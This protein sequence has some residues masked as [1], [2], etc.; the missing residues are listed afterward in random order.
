MTR[1]VAHASE[2]VCDYVGGNRDERGVIVIARHLVR[3]HSQHRSARC[4][5]LD[6][7]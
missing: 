3:A 1:H 5:L 6:I 7:N 2:Q 4:L